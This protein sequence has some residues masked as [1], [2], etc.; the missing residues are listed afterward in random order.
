MD[1]MFSVNMMMRMKR[2]IAMHVGTDAHRARRDEHDVMKIICIFGTM[3]HLLFLG[4]VSHMSTSVRKKSTTRRIVTGASHLTTDRM[5]ISQSTMRDK[6][7]FGT[8]S[9]IV[10]TWTGQIIGL[11]SFHIPCTCGQSPMVF[12]DRCIGNDC[13]GDMTTVFKGL[14]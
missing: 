3:S 11:I 13:H 6:F 14:W 1:I 9:E 4:G 8:I 10:S 5:R 12:W 2:T 7:S